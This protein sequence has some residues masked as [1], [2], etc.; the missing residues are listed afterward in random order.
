MSIANINSR[1]TSLLVHAF[2][3]EKSNTVHIA[4]VNEAKS[5]PTSVKGDRLDIRTS[6]KTC[7]Q[8]S[9]PYYESHCLRSTVK[10][11][12]DVAEVRVVTT[13]RGR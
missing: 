6:V 7:A 10:P 8:L 3:S 1:G 5:T 12:R 2:L 11:T 13:D 9:W 4:S